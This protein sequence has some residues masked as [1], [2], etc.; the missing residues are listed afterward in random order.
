MEPLSGSDALGATAAIYHI[1]ARSEPKRIKHGSK[2][3]W[4]EEFLVRWKPETRTFG[5]ILE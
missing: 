5:E 1:L 3:T 4:V 2:Y